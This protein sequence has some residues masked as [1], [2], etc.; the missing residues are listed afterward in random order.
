MN[1]LE[2]TFTLSDGKVIPVIGLGT[3]QVPNEVAYQSVK[4]ALE[5]GY[6]HIDTA[7][8]YQNEEGVGKAIKDSGIARENLFVTSKIASPIKN[9][10]DAKES[11]EE[12]LRKLDMPYIDLMLIHWPR[13]MVNGK[14]D[15]SHNYNEENVE[16]YR[17]M[18]ESYKEGK[19]KS[20][21]VSN[22]SV[23]DL[24]NI[25]ENC[26]V[27]P[28]VNQIELHIGHLLTD[29]LEFCKEND[30][31]IEAY[32]PIATGKLII[33]EGVKKIAERLNVS[34]P[35]LSL[36]YAL[37]KCA[38]V[39]PKTVHQKYMIANTQVNVEMTDELVAELEALGPISRK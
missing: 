6:T 33:H 12:S 32:S 20:I 25:L 36:A 23:D 28:V 29:T 22:F 13:P 18:E 2:K 17:A 11:I 9:Y 14:M 24:K 19:L 39:L 30:I 8:F 31:A 7:Q 37:T 26:E 21:G 15:D 16:V 34:V 1:L 27:K 4:E 38:V 10:K 3:W 35:E 5:V